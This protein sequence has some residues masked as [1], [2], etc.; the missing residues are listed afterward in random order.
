MLNQSSHRKSFIHSSITTARSHGFQGIELNGASPVP[1]SELADFGKLL[2]EWRAAITSEARNSSKPDLLLVMA[3]YYLRPSDSTSYPFDSMQRNLDWVH[4]L[5]Y[6]YYV[7][8]K[9]NIT[10]FHAAL[11]GPTNWDNTD[12]GIKEWRRRGFSSNKLVI[13]LPYHGYA[14]TLVNQGENCI[15]APA[16]GP[17]ITIAATIWVDFDDVDSIRAKVSYAKEKGLLGYSVFQLAND[18]NWILSKAA[19]EVDEDHHKRRLLIIVLLSTVTVIILLGIVFCYCHRG[20]AATITKALY[21]IRKCLSGAEQDHVEGNGSDLTAF[22]YL[23]IKMATNNFSRDNKLGEGGFGTVYKGKLRKGEEIAVKRLSESSNQGLEELKNEIALT[24]RLQHVNSVRLLGYCTKRDEKILIY[25]YLPNK[26]LDHFLFDPRKSILLDWSKRANIIEG[27]TQGLL[28]LQEYSNFTII[29][30]DLKASNILLDHNMNPKISDFGMARIFRKYDLEANTSRI[31]GTYGYVPPE[32]VR[33]GIYSTKYD[34]YSFGVLLLQIISG[35]RTSCYYGPHENMNLYAAEGD[36]A[37]HEWVPALSDSVGR[38]CHLLLNVPPNSSGLIS[39]EDIQ[40]LQEF[41][42]LRRSIFS[43]NFAIN[44]LLQASSTRGEGG[45]GGG[46]TCDSQF[47]SGGNTF[48]PNTANISGR[49]FP[50]APSS[51]FS[52]PA[53]STMFLNSSSKQPSFGF[54]DLSSTPMFQ[55]TPDVQSPSMSQGENVSTDLSIWLKEKW[56]P[57]EIPKEAPPDSVV[58]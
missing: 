7:P 45:G 57:G 56:N 15:A 30:R 3:G 53:E 50:G 6:D 55:T 43:N 36:P 34:V 19:Q 38:N 27:V 22:S 46:G 11:Y 47:S 16:S 10:G 23:T 31:V 42:E 37:G 44:A 24:A 49:G 48:T 40:V 35:K 33:K 2:E 26:S 17:A 52:T 1:A 12:S 5:A 13:G 58:R 25:E 18:D 54:N 28:Y 20:T 9:N 8:T 21:K 51:P 32:Y 14:W 39:P 4:F 29:H 41:T